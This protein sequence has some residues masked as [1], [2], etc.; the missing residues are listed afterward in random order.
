MSDLCNFKM[1]RYPLQYYTAEWAHWPERRGKKY[2]TQII[3]MCTEPNRDT[4]VVFIGTREQADAALVEAR[5]CIE[6][7]KEFLR[8]RFS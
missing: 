1:L 6:A 3:M 7:A 4:A 5:E 8:M 2:S